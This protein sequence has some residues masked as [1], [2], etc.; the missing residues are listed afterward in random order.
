MENLTIRTL[1]ASSAETLEDPDFW[2]PRKQKPTMIRIPACSMPTMIIQYPEMA[3]NALGSKLL[4][5]DIIFFYSECV[6]YSTVHSL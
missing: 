4:T 5:F 1:G 2:K 6:K 3:K